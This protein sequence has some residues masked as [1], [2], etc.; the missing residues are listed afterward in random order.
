MTGRT[1]NR[2]CVYSAN[3]CGSEPAWTC[4]EPMPLPLSTFTVAEAAKKY[5]EL[6]APDKPYLT[7]IFGKW[8]CVLFI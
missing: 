2:D 6:H 3:G 4:S 8:V 7:A 5:N 1:P